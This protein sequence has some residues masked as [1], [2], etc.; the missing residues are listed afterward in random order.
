MS[1]PSK[2]TAEGDQIKDAFSKV[3]LTIDNIVTGFTYN[4]ISKN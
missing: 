4:Q 1:I 3:N 2:I